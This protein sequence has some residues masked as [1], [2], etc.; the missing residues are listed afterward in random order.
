M[1][2]HLKTM[3]SKLALFDL[4]EDGQNITRET[5][6][7]SSFPDILTHPSISIQNDSLTQTIPHKDSKFKPP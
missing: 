5:L 3:K 4:Y 2:R 1:Y 7:V 6:D